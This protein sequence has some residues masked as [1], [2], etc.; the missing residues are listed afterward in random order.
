MNSNRVICPSRNSS[1]KFE[2]TSE[3]PSAQHERFLRDHFVFSIN[4]TRVR[5]ECLK[6]GNT[7]TFNHA[8]DLAKAEEAAESH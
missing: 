5:K 7:L 6:E 2:H 1:Q 8:K 3:K 4:S